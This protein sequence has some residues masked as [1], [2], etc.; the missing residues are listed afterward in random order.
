MDSEFMVL[1][2]S[3]VVVHEEICSMAL[4]WPMWQFISPGQGGESA[5]PASI[6]ELFER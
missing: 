1:C 4:G 2:V 6:S 3:V 5:K